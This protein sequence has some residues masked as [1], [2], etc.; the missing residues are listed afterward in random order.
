MLAVSFLVPVD[1]VYQV[2]KGSLVLADRDPHSACFEVLVLVVVE[3]MGVD[4]SPDT[5]AGL[6]DMD[7]VSL[8][9]KKHGGVEASRTGSHNSNMFANRT[10]TL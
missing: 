7:H 10:G 6:E 5:V 8:S 9:L 2:E 1:F 3:S 4:A